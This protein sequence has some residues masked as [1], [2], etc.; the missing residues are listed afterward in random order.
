[1]NKDIIVTNF[2]IYKIV[3]ALQLYIS[4]SSRVRNLDH[5]GSSSQRERYFN[6]NAWEAILISFDPD[7]LCNDKSISNVMFMHVVK[8]HRV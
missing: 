4:R 8:L 2:Y 6:V 1:M 7:P 3:D 5:N